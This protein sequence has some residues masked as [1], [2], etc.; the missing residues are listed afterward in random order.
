MTQGSPSSPLSGGAGSNLRQRSARHFGHRLRSTDAL[1]TTWPVNTQAQG[2]VSVLNRDALVPSRSNGSTSIRVLMA[3]PDASLPP[4]Y[5]E[6]LSQEGFELA[7]A[8][9]GLECV[10]RLRE[11][12]PD[13][14][15]LEPRLPWGGGDGV[16]AIME[17]S[18]ALA[19][20]CVMILTSCRDPHVLKGLERFPIS[21]YH[22]KP[23]APDRLA[24]RLRSL[25]DHPRLRFT[26]NDHCGR[27]ECAIARRTG[28]RV[29]DLHVE[30]DD[31]HVIMC[32]C[33][34][35]YHVKQLVLAAVLDAIEASEWQSFRVVSEIEVCGDCQSTVPAMCFNSKGRR[36]ALRW[37]GSGETDP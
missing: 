7:T 23:L 29:R 11:R 17:E 30:V 13:V 22:V 20:V 31:G 9:S 36:E 12:V 19:M 28:G 26:L 24:G 21:D 10:A 18:S 8:V 35:S 37:N 5:R 32:G 3:D 25:L 2:R 4:A 27:L 1:K 14:L 6:P 15:V 34:E 16:L 33:T